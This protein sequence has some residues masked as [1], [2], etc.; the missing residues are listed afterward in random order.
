MTSASAPTPMLYVDCDVPDGMTLRE[1][2][3]QRHHRERRQGL[4]LGRLFSRSRG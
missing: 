1:W 4:G 2:R 3:S